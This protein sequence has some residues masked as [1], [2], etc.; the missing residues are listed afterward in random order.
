MIARASRGRS[1]MIVF[2]DHTECYWLRALARGFRHCFVVLEHGPAWLVCDSLKSHME[3]SLLDLPES[4]DLARYYA[5][6]G[7]YVLVG[8]IGSERPRTAIAVAPLTCVSVAKRLLAIRAAGVWT[9]RQ[10]FSHLLNTKP[11]AWRA[12]SAHETTETVPTQCTIEA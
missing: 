6:Q 5:N 7:H 11:H 4:F 8:R 10:L 3:L 1:A 9:P 12:V 2:V